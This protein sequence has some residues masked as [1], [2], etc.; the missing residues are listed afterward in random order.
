MSDTVIA[1]N[2]VDSNLLLVGTKN[3][4]TIYN[5]NKWETILIQKRSV[6]DFE[7]ISTAID[8]NGAIWFGTSNGLYK[9]HNDK[10]TGLTAKPE[11]SISAYPNPTNNKITIDHLNKNTQIR[12]TDILGNLLFDKTFQEDKVE[13]ELN[14]LA[15]KGMYFIQAIQNEHTLKS[16]KVILN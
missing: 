8:K 6:V 15:P 7:V 16:F 12:I 3:G 5:G 13:I 11:N 4:L 2:F 9:I 10:S 1:L 14:Q